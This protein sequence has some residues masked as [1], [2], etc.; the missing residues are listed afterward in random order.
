MSEDLI[1]SNGIED[2]TEE[3]QVFCEV[4][5]KLAKAT[6]M[7]S[8][9]HDAVEG[10]TALAANVVASRKS[11]PELCTTRVYFFC[12]AWMAGAVSI[13]ESEEHRKGGL[14]LTHCGLAFAAGAAIVAVFNFIA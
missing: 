1:G 7:K 8:A 3:E 5:T 12:M 11:D 2:F 10:L 13:A 14:T 4:M 9:G 6:S